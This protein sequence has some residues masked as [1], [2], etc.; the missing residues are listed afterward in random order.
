Y[1][2]YQ[3]WLRLSRGKVAFERPERL[4]SAQEC[5]E[6]FIFLLS[7]RAFFFSLR[8]SIAHPICSRTP[9]KAAS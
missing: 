4:V 1:E 7:L 6:W 5:S 3:L 8:L 9:A 2:S